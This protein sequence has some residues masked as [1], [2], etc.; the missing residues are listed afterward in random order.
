MVYVDAAKHVVCQEE[1]VD[2]VS[3]FVNL[4]KHANVVEHVRKQMDHANVVKFV[5]HLDVED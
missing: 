2:V 3:V 5:V 4:I 1:C